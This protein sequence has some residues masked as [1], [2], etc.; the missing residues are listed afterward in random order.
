MGVTHGALM[1]AKQPAFEQ[2]D[3]AVDP[4]QQFGGNCGVSAKERH[5][6]VVPD[7]DPFVAVPSIGVYF[8]ARFDDIVDERLQRLG[9][10]VGDSAHSDPSDAAAHFFGRDD[11]QRFGRRRPPLRAAASHKGLVDLHPSREADRGPVESWRDAAC[12]ATP[13]RS[14]SCR[15][16]IPASTPEHSSPFWCWSRTTSRGT[17]WSAGSWCPGRWCRP[18]PRSV[19]HKPRTATAPLARPRPSRPGRRGSEIPRASAAPSS[20]PDRPP[21]S[22]SAPRIRPASADNP[23][24]RRT[25]YVAVT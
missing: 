9:F 15:A 22:R 2:R 12:A 14:D 7:L 11:N 5:T 18:S 17:T 19:V 6:M 4:R 1:S 25:L 13:T 10:S 8:A 21:R 3:H 16:P 23:P 20:R 24:R